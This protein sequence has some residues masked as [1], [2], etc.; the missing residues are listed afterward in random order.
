MPGLLLGEDRRLGLCYGIPPHSDTTLGCGWC[1]GKGQGAGLEGAALGKTHNRTTLGGSEE[2]AGAGLALQ[3][4]CSE[5]KS[6]GPGR[7][8][9]GKAQR[10]GP[11]GRGSI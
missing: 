1:F 9:S 2:K 4:L 6:Y 10:G 11:P 3:R 7:E 8:G 5:P